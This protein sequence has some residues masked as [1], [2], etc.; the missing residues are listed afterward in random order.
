MFISGT[1]GN[2]TTIRAINS[3]FLFKQLMTFRQLAAWSFHLQ[4]ETTRDSVLVFIFTKVSKPRHAK[5][6]SKV[7]AWVQEEKQPG[8]PE[9]LKYQSHE[10]PVALETIS[11]CTHA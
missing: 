3:N 4:W 2:S 6:D 10:D 8:M 7:N 11:L 5:L 1:E 9:A